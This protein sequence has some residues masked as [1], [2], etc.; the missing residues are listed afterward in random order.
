M[1]I[2]HR[3]VPYN[4]SVTMAWKAVCTS[5]ISG[6]ELIAYAD[7]VEEARRAIDFQ[8]M[9]ECTERDIEIV[10]RYDPKEAQP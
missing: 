3:K 7:T 4:T 6:E 10:G 1:S 8:I 5:P 2:V 9:R